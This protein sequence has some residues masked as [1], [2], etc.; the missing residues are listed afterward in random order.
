MRRF[1]I[2][3]IIII[4]VIILW[5]GYKMNKMPGRLFTATTGAISGMLNGSAA[6]SGPPVIIFYFSSPAGAKVSRAS[7]IS[8]FL[9]ID[10]F[11]A[12]FCALFGLVNISSAILAATLLF[13]VQVICKL[14]R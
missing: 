3:I 7:L 2:S 1:F 13:P 11:G 10:I 6:I 14:I 9:V 12:I 4:L 8:Y 5:Q